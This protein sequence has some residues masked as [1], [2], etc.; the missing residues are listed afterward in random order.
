[1]LPKENN[2][3]VVTLSNQRG[4]EMK[5]KMDEFGCVDKSGFLGTKCWV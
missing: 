5:I 1:M 2:E 3:I 4:K